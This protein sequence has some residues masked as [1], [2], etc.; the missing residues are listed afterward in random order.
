MI[1]VAMAQRVANRASGYGGRV[2]IDLNHCKRIYLNGS[3]R[4]GLSHSRAIGAHDLANQ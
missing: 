2:G 3:T 4:L 1:T